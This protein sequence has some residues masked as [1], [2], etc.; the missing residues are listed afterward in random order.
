MAIHLFLAPAGHGKTA[1]VLERIRQAHTAGPLAPITVILP[2]QPQ[3]DA[4]RRRSSDGGGALGVNLG[5]FYNLYAEVLAWAGQPAP[6]LPEA[7][8]YRLLGTIV[9]RLTSEGRLA[10]YAPLSDKPGFVT[11]LRVLIEELKR[12]RIRRDD[13]RQ[14]VHSLPRRDPRLLELSEIYAAYQDWLL[15]NGWVDLE[16]QGWPPWLWNANPTWAATCT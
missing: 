5:T 4:F 9:T 6:R 8:Q 3:V 11:A 16:G 2:N 12:A 7:V 13:F 10:Y 15:D 14:A 1:Y